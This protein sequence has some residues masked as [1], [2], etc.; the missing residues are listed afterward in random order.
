MKSYFNQIY[1]LALELDGGNVHCLVSLKN[2]LQRE[3]IP[4]EEDSGALYVL[5]CQKQI[6]VYKE[7]VLQNSL[8][9]ELE[10]V[11]DMKTDAVC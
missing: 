4:Y 7:V 1:N 11:I 6:L 9:E 2:V 3:N 10:C 5:L 8:W